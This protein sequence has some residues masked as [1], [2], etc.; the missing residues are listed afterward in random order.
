MSATDFFDNTHSCRACGEDMRSDHDTCERC[1]E[2]EMRRESESF[3]R[4]ELEEELA[5]EREAG[6]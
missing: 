2:D 3:R 1:Y 5:W 4:E 6:Q